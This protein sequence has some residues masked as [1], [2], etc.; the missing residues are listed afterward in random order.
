MDSDKSHVSFNDSQ[1]QTTSVKTEIITS[2]SM[3][4]NNLVDLQYFAG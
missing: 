3:R 2:I 4:N 1:K